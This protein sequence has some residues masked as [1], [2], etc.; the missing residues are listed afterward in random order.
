MG[1]TPK[2]CAVR[3]LFE[4]TGQRVTELSLLGLVRS[5]HVVDGSFKRNPVYFSEVAQ[6]QP[7]LENAETTNIALWDLEEQ[8]GRVDALDMRILECMTGRR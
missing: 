5:K 1:E 8:I 7:F 2:E 3:E 6:L 4:E